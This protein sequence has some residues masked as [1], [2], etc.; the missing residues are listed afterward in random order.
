MPINSRDKGKRAER[1]VIDL[2]QPVVN[3]VY[4]AHGL[5]PPVL[6]RNTLQCDSGGCDIAGLKWVAIEVKHQK[7]LYV[8]AWW[9]QACE[10]ADRLKAWPVL[11]YR[12]NHG[13]WHAVTQMHC[14][15]T[16]RDYKVTLDMEDFLVWFRVNLTREL[17][18]L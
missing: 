13:R 3:E 16:H 17:D 14:A 15:D 6:Q 11:L 10:Q 7:V 8:A 12:Q 5:T 18:V 9:A 4:E 1:Q 2:L